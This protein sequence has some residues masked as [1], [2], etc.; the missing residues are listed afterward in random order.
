MI[1]LSNLPASATVTSIHFK[2]KQMTIKAESNRL[3][4]GRHSQSGQVYLVT[5]VTKDRQAIFSDFSAAR[6]VVRTLLEEE[7]MDRAI[8]WSYV[9]MPDH[10]HWL[11]KLG[12]T[13]NLSQCVQGIKSMV[14]RQLG[15]AVWQT[16]FHDRAMRKE[17]DLPNVARYIVANPLR[18]GLVRKLGEYPHWDA[19]WL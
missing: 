18:A 4:T 9:L 12:E 16:G 14:S 8:T 11:M 6:C 13:V 2:G 7:R 15:K 1:A 17:D 10:L 5:L 3:R 19:I